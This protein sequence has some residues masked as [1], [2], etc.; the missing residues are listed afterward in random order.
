MKLDFYTPNSEIL[1]K[2]IKGFYFISKDQNKGPIKY[3]TFPNNYCILTVNQQF[4]VEDKG[5]L[6]IISSS[7]VKNIMTCVVS[8]YTRPMQ[9]YYKDLVDEL[10]IYFHPLGINHFVEDPASLFIK[11]TQIDINFLEGFNDKMRILFSLDRTTQITELES[12]LLSKLKVDKDFTIFRQMLV[13]LENELTVDELAAKYRFSRQYINRLFL[14]NL[15][16]SPSEYKKIHRFRQALKIQHKYK[17]F[18][19]LLN[20]GFYDQSHYI[21]DF[22]AFTA[23]NPNSFFKDVDVNKENVWLIVA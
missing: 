5:N 14:R 7:E 19:L 9:I 13:D 23:L 22:R 16:K 15:G 20:T 10:T 17:R 11:N 21:K 18:S 2:Y 3:W 8:R 6:V 4:E 12:Y 1:R